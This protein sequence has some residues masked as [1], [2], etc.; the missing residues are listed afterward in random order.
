M[1][2][3][4]IRGAL[5]QRRF[6]REFRIAAPADDRLAAIGEQLLA[7]L[8]AAPTHVSIDARPDAATAVW[9]A[10]RKIERRGGELP[11]AE[12]RQ[13]RRYL[14]AARQALV[15]DGLELHDH[16]GEAFHPGQ[17]LEVLVFQDEPGLDR[18]TV[19]ETVRPSVFYH[20]ER[21]QMGKVIVGRP[22]PSEPH[23]Q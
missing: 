14:R 13:V 7:A 18:Q 6:P 15:E 9:R 22:T 16:D 17:S 2:P 11:A 1:G 12:V 21:I 23:D 19:L 4:R 8:E 20:G 10:L 5:G 3:F